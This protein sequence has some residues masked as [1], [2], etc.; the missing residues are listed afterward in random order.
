MSRKPRSFQPH[1]AEL[2]TKL[3]LSVTTAPVP[4]TA[5]VTILAERVA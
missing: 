3:L 1:A 4:D 2:E 5:D